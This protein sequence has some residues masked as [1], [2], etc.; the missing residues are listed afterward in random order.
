MEDPHVLPRVEFGAAFK[1]GFTHFTDYDSRSRRS[2]YWFLALAV[3]LIE[4][5]VGIIAISVAILLIDEDKDDIVLY[6]NGFVN[7][8]I[9]FFHAS[10]C[11]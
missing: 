5:V 3:Y 9:F 6:V 7:L 11:S 1:K 10:M 8:I 2:E 4:F